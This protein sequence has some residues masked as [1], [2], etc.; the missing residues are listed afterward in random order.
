MVLVTTQNLEQM[1]E[2][3]VWDNGTG[4]P[5]E[6]LSKIFTPFYTTKPLGEGTGLGLSI[7]HEIITKEH[8]GTLAVNSKEGEYAEFIIRIPRE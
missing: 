2:I 7:A 1:V 3:R 4:I 5:N 8:V 6:E